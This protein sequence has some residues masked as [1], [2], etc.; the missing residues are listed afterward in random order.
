[1]PG[2]L[3]PTGLVLVPLQTNEGWHPVAATVMVSVDAD[4][5]KCPNQRCG[6]RD[7]PASVGGSVQ[8]PSWFAAAVSTPRESFP[9]PSSYRS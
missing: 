1:M 3:I 2:L 9:L 6:K 5:V 4:A 8:E 7:L